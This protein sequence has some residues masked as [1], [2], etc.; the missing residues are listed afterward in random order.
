MFI[1][2]RGQ[3]VQEY[4]VLLGAVVAAFIAMQVYMKRGVQGR[5]RDLANQINPKQYEPAGTTSATTINRTGSS[6]EGEYLGTYTNTG[7]DT[8]TVDYTSTTVEE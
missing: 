8:T 7:S 1:R 3:T 6:T 5:L 4:V 2:K